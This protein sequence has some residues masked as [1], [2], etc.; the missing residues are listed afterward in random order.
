MPIDGFAEGRRRAEEN[1]P[2]SFTPGKPGEGDR[3]S[4]GIAVL[5]AK[6]RRLD[7]SGA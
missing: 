4:P 2:Q 5:A 6:Y 1:E 3:D 7:A